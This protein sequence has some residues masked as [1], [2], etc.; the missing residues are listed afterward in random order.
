MENV[1]K[2]SQSRIRMTRSRILM[3]IQSIAAE[4]LRMVATHQAKLRSEEYIHL[5]DA[6][7][8]NIDGNLNPNDIGN[9]FILLQATSAVHGTCRNTCKMR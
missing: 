2:T 9:A 7:A 6:V 5:R 4:V 1:K 8:G 3:V